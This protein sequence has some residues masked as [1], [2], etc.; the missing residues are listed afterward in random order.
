MCSIIS[1]QEGAVAKRDKRIEAMRRS[2]RQVRFTQ[3]R[4]AML[5]AGF[6]VRSGSGDHW[7]F[8]HPQLSYVVT[9]DPRR[10]FVL[11]VYVRACLK[12]LDAVDNEE[13]Q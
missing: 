4:T 9:V 11:P 3:L 2:P 10:P 7:N 1:R 5:A 6:S 13:E 12:A 8:S